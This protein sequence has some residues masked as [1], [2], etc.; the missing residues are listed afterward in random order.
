MTHLPINNITRG[1]VR[2]RLHLYDLGGEAIK[3]F[4]SQMSGDSEGDKARLQE[5][6]VLDCTSC[7]VVGAGGC[8]A[9]ALYAFHTRSTLA[10]S[11]RNRHWL[12]LVGAGGWKGNKGRGKRGGGGGGILLIQECHLRDHFIDHC[13]PMWGEHS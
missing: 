1:G 2:V 13:G 10:S 7:K 4:L 8:F 5:N 6:H 11:N 3:L 12:A 9:G